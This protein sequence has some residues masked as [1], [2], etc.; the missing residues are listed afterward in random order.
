[1]VIIVLTNKSTLYSLKII[2]IFVYFYQFTFSTF[3]LTTNLLSIYNIMF[4][5][6]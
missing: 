6:S 3:P 1:M 5:S 4:T 2:V